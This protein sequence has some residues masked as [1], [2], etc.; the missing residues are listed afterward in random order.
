MFQAIYF[1]GV[2]CALYG[3]SI[4]TGIANK[5]FRYFNISIIKVCTH[6]QSATWSRPH[7]VKLNTSKFD[8]VRSATMTYF[9]K[10]FLKIL[11]F[12]L[13]NATETGVMLRS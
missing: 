8:H 9:L 2:C 1:T 4:N 10:E 7:V 11:I 5:F 6:A 12:E 3:T 13:K